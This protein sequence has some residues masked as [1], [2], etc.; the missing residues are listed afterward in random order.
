MNILF[1]CDQ[2]V[3]HYLHEIITLRRRRV[4]LPVSMFRLHKY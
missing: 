4:R 3:T 1:I 2:D